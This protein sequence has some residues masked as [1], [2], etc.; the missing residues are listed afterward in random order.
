MRPFLTCLLLTACA[1]PKEE[2]S[3]TPHY[4]WAGWNHT[5]SQLSHRVSFIRAIATPSAC[6][7]YT[8]P[9]PRDRTRSRMPSSA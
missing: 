7:L 1:D 4:I 5:W 8:S 6:L 9:S 2:A 3:P